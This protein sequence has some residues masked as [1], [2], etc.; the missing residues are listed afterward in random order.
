M[1]IKNTKV[2]KDKVK[3]QLIRKQKGKCPISGRSLTLSNS[4]L[5]HC[6]EHGHIRAALPRGVNGI[7]G[8]IT[9]LISR[10]AGAGDTDSI[11]KFLR[12]LADFLEWHKVPRTE[13]I[14][15]THK[16][17][18]EKREAR[19]KKARLAYKRSKKLCK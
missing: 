16:T 5:D 15:P 4:V 9:K 3:L 2:E 1:K 8:R 18:D 13:W 12:N 7:E 17:A 10:F 19:N 14:Y 11:I 6:H